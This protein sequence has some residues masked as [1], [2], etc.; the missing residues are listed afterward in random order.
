MFLSKEVVRV[1]S[2]KFKLLPKK[3]TKNRTIDQNRD[4]FSWQ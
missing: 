3:F 1:F 2:K 4:I